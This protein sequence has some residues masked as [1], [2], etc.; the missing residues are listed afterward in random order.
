MGYWRTLAAVPN[1]NRVQPDQTEGE[2]SLRRIPDLKCPYQ[3]AMEDNWKGVEEYFEKFPAKL[4]NQMTVEGDTAFHLAA[5]LS[6]KTQGKRVLEGLI[7]ILRNST[8]YEDRCALRVPNNNGNNTLHEVSASGNVEAAKYLVSNFNMP[9][10]EKV[11]IST[12]ASSTDKENDVLPLLETRNH[13]GETPLFRAAALGHTDLVKFYAGKLLEDNPNNLWRHF[14]RNDKMSI[15]HIAI[16]AQHFETALWFLEHYPYLAHQTEDKGL[17]SLQL[18]AQMPTAFVPQSQRSKWEMLIYYCLPVDGGDV[19][20]PNQ[21][22][23]VEINL[24]SNQRR[25]QSI[26]RNKLSGFARVYSSLWDSLAKRTGGPYG[27]I[28]DKIW[29]DKKN[30]KSLEKIVH[31]LVE[32][33]YSWL[34]SNKQ[35]KTKTI[36]LGSVETLSKDGDDGD[37]KGKAAAKATKSEGNGKEVA[38]ATKS[39]KGVTTKVYDSTPLII[40]TIKGSVSIVKEILEQHPQ[41]AEHI[42]KNERNILHVAI[43]HRQKAILKLIKSKPSVM[44]RLNERIDCV[45][46]TILHQAADRSYYSI[47]LSQNLIGPAMQL[48]AELQWMRHVRD[49]LP[50]HYGLHHNNKDQ[51]AEE[52]FY[53]EHNELLK[54]A[55]EWVK[56]TAQS[57]STVAVLVATVVFAAAYAIPGGNDQNGLPVFQDDPL[58]LLFTCMDVVA[59]ACSLSSVAFFLSVLSSPL[60]YPLFINNIPRKIMIGFVLL[61]LSMATTMLAFAATILLLIRV[62]KKWTKSILYPIAFFPVPLFGLLQFPMYHSF[63]VMFQK[64]EAWILNPFRRILGFSKSTSICGKSKPY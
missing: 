15:L 22:D 57:C 27:G 19:V 3:C 52:L 35:A 32:S 29:K 40:A 38:E 2:D 26:S 10:P 63:K 34:I 4:L 61:F 55:Q 16:I 12:S 17:T 6:S 25:R 13:L 31:L 23:D 9:D 1:Q 24:D 59:I 48:Q 43:R 14:H 37:E 49:I 54:S 45:G 39:D 30:K 42:N 50:P 64:I 46:N 20:T 62:E 11:I 18:L 47:S 53:N 28:I 33:D 36:S 60:E 7:N 41:A 8:S 21:K 56:E 51:T 44:S 58:F 5:S